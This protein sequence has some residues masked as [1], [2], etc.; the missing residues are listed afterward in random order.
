M[1]KGLDFETVLYVENKFYKKISYSCKYH[2]DLK[3][4]TICTYDRDIINS[5]TLSCHQVIRQKG[6]EKDKEGK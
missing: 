2:G 6:G 4:V 1:T 5:E 3:H